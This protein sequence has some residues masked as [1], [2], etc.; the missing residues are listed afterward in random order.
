MARFEAS[1]K[2]YISKALK[3][4]SVDNILFFFVFFMIIVNKYKDCFP[5]LLNRVIWTRLE[6]TDTGRKMENS[7]KT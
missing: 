2:D 5:Q 3:P 7:D 1:K 4:K 6:V